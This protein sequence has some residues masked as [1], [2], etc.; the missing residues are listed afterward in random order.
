[1]SVI[2][3]FVREAKVIQNPNDIKSPSD[4]QKYIWQYTIGSQ[5]NTAN[6]LTNWLTQSFHL[7]LL[8]FYIWALLLAEN[9]QKQWAIVY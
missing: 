4:D 6:A 3:S 9:G 5:N 1:M 8:W 7:Q 2:H